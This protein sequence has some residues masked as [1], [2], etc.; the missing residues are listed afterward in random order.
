MWDEEYFIEA[1]ETP[2]T[3]KQAIKHLRK[4]W[5]DY[6][7]GTEPDK[8]SLAILYAQTIL[9]TGRFKYCY[10]Y[11]VGNQKSKA[12][13]GHHW[14]MY[15]CSEVLGGKEIFFEPPHDQTK[16]RA[17]MS[18][19]DGFDHHFKFLAEK[20]RYKLAWDS[21]IDGD[22]ENYVKNLKAGGYFTASLNLYMKG[23]VRL[24]NEFHRRYNELM[25]EPEVVEESDWKKT[26]PK[27][28][29]LETE[30]VVEEHEAE[31]EIIIEELTIIGHT[32]NYTKEPDISLPAKDGNG[33]GLMTAIMVAIAA[34]WGYLQGFFQ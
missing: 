26:W 13:D 17:F 2:I 4:S 18:M 25:E 30:M 12:A 27:E 28:E 34:A 16:F 6:Y 29:V 3:E 15:K 19:Q 7:D 31:T 5:M 1:K 23:M 20:E 10:C 21:L 14:T 22:V 24:T 8:N 9:E 32:A 33:F 11:N